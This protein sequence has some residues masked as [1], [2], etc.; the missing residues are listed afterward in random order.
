LSIF[1]NIPDDIQLII[2]LK[3]KTKFSK[4]RLFVSEDMTPILQ[5]SDSFVSTK[6]IKNFLKI[7]L[8]GFKPFYHQWRLSLF[9][10]G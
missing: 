2:G 10:L 9:R 7:N 1:F 3:I 4:N 8:L 5:A 6:I